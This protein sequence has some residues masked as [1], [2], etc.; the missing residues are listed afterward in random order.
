MMDPFQTPAPLEFVGIL[1]EGIKYFSRHGKDFL[2]VE[3]VLC[4]NGHS[5]MVDAV[6]IN[7]EPTIRIGVEIG[8]QKGNFFIDSFWGSHEKLYDF[9]PALN[10]APVVVKALCP[11]CGT[12]LMVEDRCRVSGCGTREHILLTLPGGKNKIFVCGRLGC[13]GHRLEVQSAPHDLV[14]KISEINYFGS[15]E[16]DF[17]GGI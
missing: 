1:P 13:P 17:F 11:V 16:D 9:I 2:V 4:P 3:N 7:G 6:R 12:S 14:E 10:A 15:S 8:P 5:L